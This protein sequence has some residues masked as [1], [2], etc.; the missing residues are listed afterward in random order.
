MKPWPG[1]A[2]FSKVPLS[3]WAQMVAFAGTVELFQYVAWMKSTAKILVGWCLLE[4]FVIEFGCENEILNHGWK[5]FFCKSFAKVWCWQVHSIFVLFGCWS[6]LLKTWPFCFFFR[7]V[8]D[9]K[10][11][12]GDF[13]NAGFLGVPNGYVKAPAGSK[14]KKLAAEIANGRLAMM[15]IIGMFFQ[16]GLTGDWEGKTQDERLQNKK[17]LY[18]WTNEVQAQEDVYLCYIHEVMGDN[19]RNNTFSNFKM[20]LPKLKSFIILSLKLTTRFLAFDESLGGL[21]PTIF[22]WSL[23][24]LGALH[25][26]SLEG[27]DTSA[28]GHCWHRWPLPRE[29]LGPCRHHQQEEQG[30]EKFEGWRFKNI[31]KE[32]RYIW[33]FPKIEGTPPKSSICS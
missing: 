13:E 17:G 4:S 5:V 14:E 30:G 22:R 10:R 28:G 19:W 18:M 11:P 16:N 32:Q 8:D 21:A 25:G 29:F 27:I 12:P 26:F 20:F 33:V 3:G 7:E 24:R 15:A 23:G 6:N 31:C 2:A 1:F 9:P